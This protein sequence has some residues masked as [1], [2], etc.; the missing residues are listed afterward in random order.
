MRQSKL[1]NYEDILAALADKPSTIDSI[2]YSGNM[3]CVLLRQ[4]IDFLIANNLI[5]ERNY[6]KKTLYALTRRGLSIFKTLRLTKCLEKLQNNVAIMD[7]KTW[8]VEALQEFIKK[9][10]RK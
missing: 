6:E 5:E 4:R 7:Q 2:A 3:D 10:K 1:E 8:E 9:P